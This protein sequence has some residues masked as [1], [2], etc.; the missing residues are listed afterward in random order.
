MLVQPVLFEKPHIT[1]SLRSELM[2]S[3]TSGYL[4]TLPLGTDVQT[5]MQL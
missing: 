1:E 4:K 5:K 2:N 3:N